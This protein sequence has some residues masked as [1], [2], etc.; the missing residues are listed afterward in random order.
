MKMFRKAMAICLA[1]CLCLVFG[2]ILFRIHI[3]E[4]YPGDTVRMVFTAPLTEYYNSKNGE[5]T[6][7]TQ[8]IR[9]P[10]DSAEDGNFFASGLIVVRDAG[11][12]QVTV[13][14]NES[15]LPRVAAFYGLSET[16]APGE[17]LFRYTLTASYNTTEEGDDYR[18][19]D[20]A[21][22]SEDSAYMYRYGKLVFDGV[23]FEGAAW[24]RVDIYYGEE[25]TP[26]GHIC[27]YESRTSDG[28]SIIDVPF[29]PYK[30]DKE[31]LPK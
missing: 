29:S 10:Y 27:V 5:I 13:R 25:T 26:F 21:Y 30:I 15:T 19:Y 22:L 2:G 7:E 16:P 11:N 23:D 3:A 17:G 12:L 24:M 18:T 8:N 9:F 14:Y 1:L 28:E 20:A 6:A 31:D 4:H